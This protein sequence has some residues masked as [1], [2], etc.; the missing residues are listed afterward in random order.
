MT[1][2]GVQLLRARVRAT[3]PEGPRLA[4]QAQSGQDLVGRLLGSE[5]PR[6]TGNEWH[7]LASATEVGPA[8]WVAAAG[9]DPEFILMCSKLSRRINTSNCLT[10][11]DEFY[12]LATVDA[13][14]SMGRTPSVAVPSLTRVPKR[15]RN[16]RNLSRT[17]TRRPR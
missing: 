9:R 2:T 4:P 17:A 1:R 12:H 5:N 16:P 8:E 13:L 6:F 3:R 14:R 15:G 7:S 10:L 11:L